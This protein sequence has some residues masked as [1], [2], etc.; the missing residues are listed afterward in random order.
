MFEYAVSF[1]DQKL[2]IS[3]EAS[4]VKGSLENEINI[5][6]IEYK[7]GSEPDKITV[8]SSNLTSEKV[9]L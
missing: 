8:A 1:S 3:P 4:E 9:N 2:Y 7:E 6:K 5:K